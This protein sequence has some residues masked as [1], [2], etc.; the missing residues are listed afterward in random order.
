MRTAGRYTLLGALAGLLAPGALFV[1]A[2]VSKRALDP[3]WL[4][5]LLAAGGTTVFAVLGRMI[6]LRDERLEDLSESDA[7]TNVANRRAFDR[8]LTLELSRTKRYGISSALVMIDLDRFKAINDRFGHRAG[9]EILRR[10]GSLLDSE[11]RAGDLVARYGGEEFV[12]ILPHTSMTAAKNWAERVRQY[13][14]ASRTHWKGTDIAVTA[15][16]GVAGTS[17]WSATNDQLIEAADQ[18]LYEAK[19]RGGN[20]VVDRL[21]DAG[22]NAGRDAREPAA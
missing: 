21:P 11:R 19:R 20:V 8:R 7:L 18:A 16:F 22:V 2:T 3:F 15:S 9:D 17:W 1:F 6:G 14:A 13:L 5:V 10:L 12:A 4:A